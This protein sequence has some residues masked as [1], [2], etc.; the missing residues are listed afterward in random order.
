MNMR[1]TSDPLFISRL[2]AELEREIFDIAVRAF[3]ECIRQVILV[4]CRFCIWY[5]PELYR[6][7]R[8][9]EGRVVPP[10]YIPGQA[11]KDHTIGNVV[12]D[13][14]IPRLTQ[15]G[16]HVRHVLLQKRT[17]QE[18]QRVLECCP[19]VSNLA[20]WII[21]GKCSD[22]VPILE[23]LPLQRLSFDPS[24]FFENYA[25]DM[26]MPFDQPLF[27]HIT[28]L[29]IINATSSWS[30]WRQLTLLPKLTHLALAGT[31][32]QQLIDHVLEGC[33]SLELLIMFNMHY[34]VLGGDVAAAQKDHRVVFLKSVTNHLDHWEK[35][36]RGEEDFWVTAGRLKQKVVEDI[37]RQGRKDWALHF[38]SEYR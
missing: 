15:Y 27:H 14:D 26:S 13:V 1:A 8:S 23:R 29:E 18:I 6:I 20:L 19:N 9:G 32:N 30:K 3:P 17:A 5:E 12:A 31:V 11:E 4:A 34:E 37:V 10:L 25:A 22:L 33:P 2:P 28:H 24:Y 7:M 21:Q 38:K 16:P 35:G 36:A